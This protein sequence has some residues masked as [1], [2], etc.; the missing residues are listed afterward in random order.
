[1]MCGRRVRKTAGFTLIELM[2]VVVIIGILAGLAIPRF[3]AVAN[4]V[5]ER[6]AD[7]ILKQ[8]H[9]QQTAYEGRYGIF[10]TSYAQLQTT[11]WAVPNLKYFDIPATP[12]FPFCMTNNGGGTYAD[13]QITAGGIIS[14]C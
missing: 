4:S 1:M 2:I 10:A 6:E 14:N 8:M 11:G 5:K 3:T 9:T 13:R 7:L 12:E